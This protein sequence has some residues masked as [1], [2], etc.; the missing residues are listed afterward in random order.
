MG[1]IL[2]IIFSRIKLFY[3]IT[4]GSLFQ[5][6][7]YIFSTRK[8]ALL[9]V[10]IRFSGFWQKS[11]SSSRFRLEWPSGKEAGFVEKLCGHHAFGNA[12]KN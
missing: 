3:E 10:N 2:P 5:F 7:S 4:L 6:A 8:G 11:S 9:S 1:D 12:G